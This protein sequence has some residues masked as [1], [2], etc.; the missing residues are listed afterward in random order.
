M[1]GLLRKNKPSS[2]IWIVLWDVK[3]YR[4]LVIDQCIQRPRTGYE[5]GQAKMG[6]SKGR[7]RPS[8]YQRVSLSSSLRFEIKINRI[9]FHRRPGLFACLSSDF[10]RKR[11]YITPRISQWIMRLV[12]RTLAW[13][14][15]NILVYELVGPFRSS[16]SRERWVW[17]WCLRIV[18]NVNKTMTIDQPGKKSF[19]PWMREINLNGI[20]DNQNKWCDDGGWWLPRNTPSGKLHRP[21]GSIGR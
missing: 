4:S 19:C 12:T 6:R 7:L 13:G 16:G 2:T 5:E 14:T 8:R 21:M 18:N 10:S 11:D 3:T 17:G 9:I 1:D 15:A 20:N